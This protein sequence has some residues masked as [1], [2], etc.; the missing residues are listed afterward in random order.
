MSSNKEIKRKQD[1][2]KK[3]GW[4]TSWHPSIWIKKSWIEEGKNIDWMGYNLDVAYDFCQEELRKEKEGGW[5]K[6]GKTLV[7][8]PK[9]K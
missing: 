1:F 6:E 5:I 7:F 2:L 4:I 8:R 9:Q 3:N